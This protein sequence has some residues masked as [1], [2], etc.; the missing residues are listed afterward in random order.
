MKKAIAILLLVTVLLTFLAAYGNQDSIVVCFSMEQFR[1][2]ALQAH[3]RE[4][5]PGKNII[6]TYMPTGKAA[7]KVY[8]EGPRTEI[9]ILVG[10]ETGYLN[11]IA[12]DLAEVPQGS[13]ISYLP[14]FTQDKNK[15][16]W[17]TWEKQAGAIV[18]NTEVLAKYGLEAPSCYEDLLKPEY[19][20]LIAMP[21]PKSSGTGYFF[22]KSWVNSMGE[23][24]A[25]NYVD[26]LHENLKQFTESGS[27]P[28]KMLKQ[29]EV[30]I[31]LG[32]TFQAVTERNDGQP[33]EIIF[34]ELGS[35][36]SL[37]GT[38][39]LKGREQDPEIVEVFR[40]IINDALRYDKENFSPETIYEEQINK[41]PNYPTDIPYADMT[42]IQD[43]LEK[44][45]LLD[46]W[47]Y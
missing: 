23:E 17:V 14:D 30:A 35:P 18:V 38:A 29:G 36:Y 46:L 33:F 21:D 3:L 13:Q 26:K 11:K 7:S 43:D 8:A 4:Q 42:G 40:Y 10:L 16:K 24:A 19:K 44:E 27:G 39:L 5:F 15:N 12:D 37:T 2:D 28:I 47:K 25:L 41:I 34:P 22:F 9:D 45:R 20:D 31:G 1:G 32:L 6:V